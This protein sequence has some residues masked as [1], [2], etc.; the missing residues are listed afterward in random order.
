ML[1]DK[2]LVDVEE[3]MHFVPKPF[4]ANYNPRPN[5]IEWDRKLFAH[6]VDLAILKQ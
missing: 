6:D 5:D 4:Q 1:V 2:S 3:A